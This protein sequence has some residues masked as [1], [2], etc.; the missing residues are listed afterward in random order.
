M[1][2]NGKHERADPRHREVLT[3]VSRALRAVH[4]SLV[5]AV[6]VGYEKEHGRV[7]SP[8]A[9]L[10]LVLHD[11]AFAWLRPMSALIVELAELVED[12][13]A[14]VDSATLADVR[15]AIERWI[16]DSGKPSDFSARY[17]VVLQ[18]VPEVVMAHGALRKRLATLPQPERKAPRA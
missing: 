7:E 6:Q 1:E 18:N 11:P 8:G 9:L 17:L 4:K 3:E 2:A 15:S 5:A 14:L 12:D 10:Q 16:T 13:E